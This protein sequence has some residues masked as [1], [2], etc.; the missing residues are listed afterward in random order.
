MLIC[1]VFSKNLIIKEL[2]KIKIRVSCH[3]FRIDKAITEK[4]TMELDLTKGLYS[5]LTK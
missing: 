5:I 2:V 1:N 4:I 3:K